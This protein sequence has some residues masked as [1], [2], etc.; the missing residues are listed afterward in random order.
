MGSSVNLKKNFRGIPALQKFYTGGPYRLSSDASFLVC[1]CDDEVKIVEVA[2]GFVRSTLEGDSEPITALALTPDDKLLFAASRSAQVKLWDL[3]S[4]TCIRSWK[5]HSGPVADMTCDASGGLL[6]T[7]GAD[8]NILVWDVDGGFCTHSFRGH[9]MGVTTVLF[10]LDPRGRLVLISGSTD[11]TVRIWDLKA[12]KCIA[13]LEK[14]FSVVTSLAISENGWI[15]LSASRDKVVNIWDL[16]DYHFRETILTYEPLETVC[17]IPS[18]SKLVSGLS[19]KQLSRKKE[20]KSDVYPVHFLTV[21]ERGIIRIW[22]SEGAICLYEQ[23]SSDAII[24]S[25]ED[26]LK[27]GFVSAVL[28]P[29]AQGVLCVTADQRFLFYDLVESDEDECD[30]RLTKQLIGY[31]EEV[32]DLKF[33][34]E[35][36]NLLAVAT[37][38]EQLRVYELASMAC[39]YELK[40]HTGIVLCLDSV[41]VSGKVLLA[42]GAQ[43]HSVRVWDTESRSCLC[44]ATG[45]MGA[46][47][48]VAFS[49]KAKNFFVSGSSDRTIKLWNLAN[50]LESNGAEE[51]AKLTSQATVAA[52]DKDINSVAVAPNDSLVCTGSQDKTARVWRLP[53]LVP[54]MVLRGHKRG[55]WCVEFSPVDQCVMTASGDKT[56]KIWA[57]SDGSCLK[58]FE[59]H[60]ASVLR[61]SFLTR[62]TQFISSGADGLLKLWTVKSNECIATFDQHEDKIW[63][64]A[65]GKKTEM[66]ASG[67]SDSLVNL[68]HDCTAA[69]EEEALL[70]EAEE[71]L[72]DQD[73]ANAL[74]DTNY[75]KAIQLAFELRRPYK[76]LNIF[77]EL[78]RIRH[79]E[80][81]MRTVISSLG[82]EE[83]RLLLE[84]VRE[85][86]TKPKFCHVAQFVLFHLFSVLPPSDIMEVRGINEL[87]EGLI[88]YSQRHYSRID[89]F[90]RSTF[91]L[92]YTLASMSVLTPPETVLPSDLPFRTSTEKEQ[93]QCS[94]TKANLTTVEPILES[95]KIESAEIVM[96]SFDREKVSRNHMDKTTDGDYKMDYTGNLNCEPSVAPL[97]SSKKRKSV[98]SRKRKS[99]AIVND[100]LTNGT[101]ANSTTI[102]LQC[103]ACH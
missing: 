4:F 6:A 2:N 19:Q 15:L 26:E 16:H 39:T 99:S 75:V 43:D 12:K 28:Q 5:A 49:K 66:L 83:E 52:H 95:E 13:V 86:N 31:N 93:H 62:G 11:A 60:T 73:L 8:R 22:F 23:K 78:Q 42:S 50:V 35:E 32:V 1:A 68:W 38:S 18:V 40:G 100:D 82:K 97:G 92:D 25:N 88:P 71:T 33:V 54:L 64:L 65:V 89:R 21:G 30:L 74:A 44:V 69:D 80:N 17:V 87:L 53:H 9:Q 76:L 91:L 14:H 96:A 46:I 56:I 70:K 59:G 36:E 81:H 45:H 79:E 72:K 20:K 77:T 3:S 37:N 47:G 90:V 98:S 67:G 101:S 103:S 51:P 34:G 55:V 29:S 10:H 63:A 27:G 61:A 94:V 85:W 41:A 48:A 84:Y 102:A 57:L 24:S 7:A 58:T